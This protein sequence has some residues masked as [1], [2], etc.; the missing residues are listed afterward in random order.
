MTQWGMPG[1]GDGQ[2]SNPQGV[3]VDTKDKVYVAD[4]G[5]NRIQV[6][7][8]SGT[9]LTQWGKLGPGDGQ[10][11]NPQG[12]AVDTSGSVY[13]ADS[14]NNR[15]QKFSPGGAYLTQWATSGTPI[16]VAVDSS[17]FVY[18]AE[19][20]LPVVQ[21]FSSDGVSLAEWQMNGS[22]SPGYPIG[23]ATDTFGA[24]YV[25]MTITDYSLTV[26]DYRIVKLTSSGAYVTRWGLLGS[27][28][29]QFSNPQGLAVNTSGDVIVADS[30]NSRI[31]VFA[32]TPLPRPVVGS[33]SPPQTLNGVVTASIQA[34]GVVGPSAIARVWAVII[35]PGAS[36][37][38]VD[39]TLPSV[40]GGSYAATLDL[41][42][43]P[44]VYWIAIYAVDVYGS[45]AMPVNTS[46]TQESDAVLPD[47]YE[48]DGAPQSAS[49]LTE[50]VLQWH[51]FHVSDDADWVYVPDPYLRR[52]STF[53]FGINASP[54]I[55]VYGSDGVTPILGL[56]GGLIDFAF[57]IGPCYLRITNANAIGQGNA[58]GYGLLLS[59]VPNVPINGFP[60]AITGTVTNDSTHLP[61]PGVTVQLL[62]TMD[63]AQTD[64][65]GVFAFPVIALSG[66]YTLK[67]LEDGFSSTPLL[68]YVQ[69]PFTTVAD[70][71]V[72][73]GA[74]TVLSVR[75]AGANPANASTV[76]FTITFSESVSG[77]AVS[78]FALTTTGGVLGASVTS[79]TGSGATYTVDVNTGSGDGTIR[80]DVVDRDTIVGAVSSL[81]LGGPGLGNGNFTGGEEYTI[82]KTPPSVSMSSTTLVLTNTTPIPVIVTFSEPV[83]G[84]TSGG[85]TPGNA[86]VSGFSGSG[87]KYGFDLVPNGHGAVTADIAAGVAH[88]AAGNGSLAALQ[89][90][91]N[92]GPE[93]VDS[94]G[95]V[96]AVDVQL[97]INAALGLDIHG[98]NADVNGDSIVDA[99]DIQLVINAALGL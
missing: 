21:K 65:H 94:S 77:V 15:I 69:N 33:V 8:S 74:A 37:S 47:I 12:V 23:I 30:G 90:F 40:G 31:Q 5:N 83:T 43:D 45:I 91:R 70:I 88:D 68:V 9:Y 51:N 78:D 81:P 59:P 4:S 87:A 64:S 38:V 49:T 19:N 14:G 80:L 6:F 17:D 46:V 86:S 44:G 93:D 18:V 66:F 89:F 61:I 97:V 52:V 39:V 25:S 55:S 24:I 53:R 71:F 75:R 1:S 34:D 96:D 84:F 95:L 60:G 32:P 54:T 10:F 98:L 63:L 62:P 29:G 85:I 41:F 57:N 42:T 36:G 92:G 2:F 20:P 72:T 11:T 67:A 73:G 99:V 56:D 27:G 35:A 26:T 3:A 58:T 28:E 79:V 13:V 82:D 22:D 16:G 7:T 48:D 76:A 50:G